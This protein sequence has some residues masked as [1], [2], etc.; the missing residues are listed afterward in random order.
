MNINNLGNNLHAVWD[1]YT[2]K[3]AHHWKI[4]DK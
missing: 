4:S 2:N 1:N 3:D